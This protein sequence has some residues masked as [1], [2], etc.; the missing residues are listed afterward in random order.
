[1]D[2]PQRD[3]ALERDAVRRAQRIARQLHQVLAASIA[4]ASLRSEEE[5]RHEA[6]RAGPRGL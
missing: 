6:R 4:V 3:P 2:G 1:M 5:L